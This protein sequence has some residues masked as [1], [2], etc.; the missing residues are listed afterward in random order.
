MRE[1]AKDKLRMKN[2]INISTSDGVDAED[3]LYTL[4]QIYEEKE[5]DLS[6]SKSMT[7]FR[8]ASLRLPIKG[9]DFHESFEELKDQGWIEV[10]EKNNSTHY[11]IINHP[12]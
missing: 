9:M 6:E 11:R 5:W 12:W 7:S 2:L 1:I 8:R 10:T 4:F 3:L